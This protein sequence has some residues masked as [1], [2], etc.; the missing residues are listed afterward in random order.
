VIF[1]GLVDEFDCI[2]YIL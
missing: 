1:V 2:I